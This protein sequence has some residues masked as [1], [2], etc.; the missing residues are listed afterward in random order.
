VQLG[1]NFLARE[2]PA[3]GF[4]NPIAK[5]RRHVQQ[6][7]H[8]LTIGRKSGRIY[9]ASNPDKASD[10]H[11]EGAAEIRVPAERARRTGKRRAM[12]APD[13]SEWDA[14]PPPAE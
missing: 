12:S 1:V 4:G 8:A 10:N 3:I 11:A 6:S 7:N 5:S 9:P 14:K 2:N 13:Y